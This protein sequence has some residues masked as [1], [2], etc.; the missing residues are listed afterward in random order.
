MCIGYIYSFFDPRINIT[1]ACG[2]KKNLFTRKSIRIIYNVFFLD[3]SST[4]KRNEFGKI[5][6]PIQKK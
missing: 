4:N 2:E 6:I 3:L 1:Y 5:K